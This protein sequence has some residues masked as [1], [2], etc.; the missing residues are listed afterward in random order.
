MPGRGRVP[1]MA[2]LGFVLGGCSGAGAVS[3]AAPPAAVVEISTAPGLALRF[4]PAEATVAAAGDVEL[5][6]HNRSSQAHNLVF[7]TGVSAAT[8]T[9]V[10]AGGM[11]RVVFATTGP[12][13]YTFVCT[14][15]D[16]MQ[17]SVQVEAPPTAR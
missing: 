4:E 15:H 8:R 6:F 7:T 14:I 5:K 2:I 9:I 10:E 3:M 17:G 12:G 16:G 13:T 1:L 11:D